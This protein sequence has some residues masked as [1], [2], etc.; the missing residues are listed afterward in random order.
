MR[1]GRLAPHPFQHRE[2]GGDEQ[3][4]EPGGGRACR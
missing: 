1:G 2:E 3:H 4:D